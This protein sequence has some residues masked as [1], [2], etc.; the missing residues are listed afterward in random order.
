M[1]EYVAQLTS[2]LRLCNVRVIEKR[3]SNLVNSQITITDGLHELLR[4]K[5]E[6]VA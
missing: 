3:G 2:L 6:I 5:F 1:V 4:E